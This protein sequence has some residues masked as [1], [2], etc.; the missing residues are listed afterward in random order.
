M[1]ETME[2]G[3][4]ETQPFRWSQQLQRRVMRLLLQHDTP[5]FRNQFRMFFVNS[6]LPQI[7]LLQQYDRYLKL[8]LLSS[9]L[10]DDI[11]P[12]IRRQLSLKTSH[13]RLHEEAPTRGDMNW[14]PCMPEL[15]LSKPVKEISMCSLSRWQRIFALDPIPIVIFSPGGNVSPSSVSVAQQMHVLSLWQASVAM[16][17]RMLGSTNSGLCLSAFT[18]SMRKAQCRHKICWSTQTCS[19]ARLS[20]KGGISA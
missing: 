5:L 12:R 15:S 8:Q 18:C 16:R 10:L 3:V 14:Q 9:E 7:P 17:R 6:A 2:T 1:I 11:L 19:N 13:A 4:E 20:G